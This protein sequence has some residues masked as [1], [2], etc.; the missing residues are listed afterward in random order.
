MSKGGIAET[1]PFSDRHAHR[2]SNSDRADRSTRIHRAKTVTLHRSFMILS[3]HSVQD[4]HGQ[5][6]ALS[7]SAYQGNSDQHRQALQIRSDQLQPAM[8]NLDQSVLFD[9]VRARAHIQ[10]ES[11][12]ESTSQYHSPSRPLSSAPGLAAWCLR[13][14]SRTSSCMGTTF[15]E[16]TIPLVAIGLISAHTTVHESFSP[17]VFQIWQRLSTVH[18]P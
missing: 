6:S 18:L 13:A 4:Q 14:T 3:R 16:Y 7:A 9:N 10:V 1:V 17:L 15:K 8:L 2:N 11:E 12:S 5:G